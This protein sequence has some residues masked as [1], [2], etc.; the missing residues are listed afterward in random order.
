MAEGIT[1]IFRDDGKTILQTISY[2]NFV[3]YKYIDENKLEVIVRTCEFPR[4]NLEETCVCFNIKP[5][6][7]HVLIAIENWSTELRGKV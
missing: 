1:V 2:D 7:E 4:K 6:N 3:S 5:R